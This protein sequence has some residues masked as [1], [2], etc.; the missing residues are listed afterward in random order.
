LVESRP[1]AGTR[2][3]PR[4][5]WNLLDP[6]VLAW[7]F[8]GEPDVEYVRN[9]F[10]LRM[11]VEPEAAR[12]AAIRASSDDLRLMRDALAAMRRHSLATEA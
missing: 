12:L 1:K 9:L 5:R 8:A 7:A 3:L 4:H 10:E 11:I 6:D 2:V